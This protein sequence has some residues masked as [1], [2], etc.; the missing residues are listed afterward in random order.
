VF[1]AWNKFHATGIAM[2]GTE[3]KDGDKVTVHG[4]EI[5]VD[6]S[7]VWITRVASAWNKFHATAGV[8]ISIHTKRETIRGQ[9]WSEKSAM[10]SEAGKTTVSA[11]SLKE[12]EVIP[13]GD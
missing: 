12:S 5:Q 9:A 7:P 4:R 1:V 10:T 8:W 6:L 13:V 2:R 3:Q 11:V